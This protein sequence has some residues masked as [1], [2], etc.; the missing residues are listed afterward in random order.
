MFYHA[1]GIKRTG[2]ESA[3]ILHIAVEGSSRNQ[4]IGRKMMNELLLIE[5]ISE[6]VAETDKDAVDL[7]RR[8]GFVVF[9][10]NVHNNNIF[11]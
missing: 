8:C 11:Y 7:H 2:K 10:S 6:M 3:E 1:I 9:G 5:D 4:G